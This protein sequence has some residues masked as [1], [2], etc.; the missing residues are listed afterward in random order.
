MRQLCLFL[1]FAGVLAAQESRSSITGRIIDPSGAGVPNAKVVLLQSGTNARLEA[2]TD[3]TGIYTL[4][5][6]A[7]GTYELSLEVSGFKKY[8]HS[9]MLIGTNQRL[10]E[11]IELETGET[12]ELVGRR[13]EMLPSNLTTSALGRVVQR[14]E[15][16]AWPLDGTTPSGFA[17]TA[18]NVLPAEPGVH[19]PL[20]P[21][22]DERASRV[23]LGA[24][25]GYNDFLLDGVPN[26]LNAS[27]EL[28]YTPPLEAIQEVKA[29]IIQPDAGTGSLLGGALN[30]VTRSG[31]KDLHG[32]FFAN[33]KPSGLASYDYFLRQNGFAKPSSKFNQF[34][35]A[36]GGE[37]P[38][39]M[40]E[41]RRVF[42]FGSAEA[43]KSTT[44]EVTTT[45]VPTEAERNGD[46]SSL[47]S[48]TGNNL[49][50]DPA[51][52]VLGATRLTRTSFANNIIPASRLNS[53]ARKMLSYYPAANLTGFATGENNFMESTPTEWDY[54]SYLGRVDLHLGQKNR[55]FV[56]AQRDNFTATTPGLFANLTNGSSR[57][58]TSEGAAIDD[59]YMLS[60][61]T[62][63]NVRAGLT[64]ST[65]RSLANSSGFSLTSLGLPTLMAT[66]ST[67]TAFPAIRFS[68]AYATLGGEPVKDSPYTVGQV[69]AA[70][71]R[72]HGKMTLKAGTDLRLAE[73]SVRDSGY[74]A[75]LFNFGT[76]YM[77]S[78]SN[79]YAQGFGGSLA[80][81]LLGLPTSGQYDI[82][83]AYTYKSQMYNVFFQDDWR[84]ASTLTISLGLRATHETPVRERYD[85]LVTGFDASLT[86]SV[87]TASATA[88]ENMLIT[89][90]SAAKFRAKGG[91]VYTDPQQKEAYYVRWG[92]VDPRVGVS[93]APEA[94]NGRTTVRLSWGRFSDTLGT[95]LTG[96]NTGYSQTTQFVPTN[97]SFIGSYA[98][99]SNPYPDGISAPTGSA[100]GVNSNLGNPV[101]YYSD[102]IN[103][104]YA[105]RA[106]L[107][108]QQQ[109]TP[110]L[111]FEFGLLANRQKHLPYDRRIS[112][113]AVLPHLS[114][115]LTRDQTI[116]NNLSSIT[117]NPFQGL[118]PGTTRNGAYISK[119][120]LLQS[121]PQFQ[122][123]TENYITDG[124]GAYTEFY[125]RMQKRFS[126]GVTG[127][128]SYARSK[129]LAAT[130]ALNPGDGNLYYGVTD[131]NYPN[132]L[133]FL[134]NYDLPFGKGKKYL[135]KASRAMD[136]AVG[137]WKINALFTG[138][139]GPALRF[140]NVI[141]FGS[142]LDTKPREQTEAFNMDAF[143]DKP[144]FQLGY[145]YRAVAPT[146][147]SKVRADA[148]KN[149]DFSLLKE[150]SF[151]ERIGAQLHL[152]AFNG[153][154]RTQFGPANTVP[155]SAAFTTINSQVNQS[156]TMQVGFKLHF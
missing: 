53:V 155:T 102:T 42:F 124:R 121:Y 37:V 110:T 139:S 48:Y 52:G 97:N 136:L 95:R 112:S 4:P 140:G 34:G 114:Q 45:T 134:L 62:W 56:R 143:E 152:D 31:G 108:I 17:S 92:T 104:P 6:L 120:E 117:P 128:F 60:P 150:F 148:T 32:D 59:V 8:V 138:Q 67:Q 101:W 51:T 113:S 55:M 153:A 106:N 70:V 27:R 129:H 125:F 50:Y 23:S 135:G 54:K 9:E 122:S 99:L 85:R 156:R 116:I 16:N 5:M 149:L 100:L 90:L 151:T 3:S 141:Y 126:N 33:T 115:K 36:L 127:T 35:G 63:I 98:T 69:Y 147:S 96:P 20:R 12:S 94:L 131:T 137:G 146:F 133:L 83:G 118:L 154:N 11:D 87:S 61:V 82:N 30:F 24:G 43:V 76:N 74:S 109:V 142:S 80:S 71:T 68:D 44:N 47:L 41:S 58:V 105:T 111:Q 107:S 19:S 39:K 15:A 65:V 29:E 86:N 40:G 18:V 79:G 72:V 81:M 132:R 73:T 28:G 77:M 75:G 10:A 21:F 89:E 14:E 78:G 103:P 57:N 64:R 38:L 88:Y 2:V 93:W 7:P 49:L 91:M 13:G 22:E 119:A 144:A 46:F 123:V 130:Y 66:N 84:I 25:F 1:V 26:T 145:N